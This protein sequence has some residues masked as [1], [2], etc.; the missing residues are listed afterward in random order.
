MRLTVAISAVAALALAA[1]SPAGGGNESTAGGDLPGAPKKAEVEAGTVQLGG[2]AILVTGPMGTSLA[3]GSPREA[4][5]AELT[6]VLGPSG[7]KSSNGECG[8]GPMEF[9]K[10]DPGLTLNFQDGKLVGWYLEGNSTLRSDKGIGIGSTAAE[11][12]AA[13]SAEPLEDS[14]LGAEYYSEAGNIGA[15]MSESAEKPVVE[16]L[17]SGTNCFFR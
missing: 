9:T 3:F 16:S 11:F 15:I 8:A 10:F 4:V 6:K 1:C 13:H 12:V 2:G 14:T 5:E 7:E 17:Y